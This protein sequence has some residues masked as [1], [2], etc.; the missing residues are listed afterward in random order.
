MAPIVTRMLAGR[1]NKAYEYLS[2]NPDSLC[3]V[4][5][6]QGN[7]EGIT[8]AEAMKRYLVDKGIDPQRI[9]EEGRSTNTYENLLYSKRIM[10]EMGLEAKAI[11]VTDGFHEWRAQYIAKQ[12]GIDATGLGSEPYWPLQMCYWIREIFGVVRVILLG[13]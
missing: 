4:S 12:V 7:N 8:E 6:G 5:G 13:Y 9:I 10:D 2:E 1:L 3:I 11:I